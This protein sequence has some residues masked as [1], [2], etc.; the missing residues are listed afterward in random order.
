MTQRRRIPVAVDYGLSLLLDYDGRIEYLPDGY[1]LK[2][3]VKTTGQTKERPHGL[4]YSFTLHDDSNKRV[5]GYDNAHSVRALGRKGKAQ[6][7]YDHLHRDANDKGR[8]YAFTD[9]AGLLR[10]FYGEVRR[11]LEGRGIELDIIGEGTTDVE[12]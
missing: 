8:P 1:Y 10:D 12:A 9:A 6:T 2:F 11:I 5:L 4:S 7:T 3:Q